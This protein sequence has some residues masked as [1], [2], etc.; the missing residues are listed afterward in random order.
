[1]A[2][3]FLTVRTVSKLIR[4]ESDCFDSLMSATVQ[5][6]LVHLVR[7]W[8]VSGCRAIAAIC[9]ERTG[10]NHFDRPPCDGAFL[11]II[12]QLCSRVFSRIVIVT[13]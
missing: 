5:N 8:S 7:L 9:Q 13:V 1:M 4:I 6:E 11:Y 12:A 10:V 3:G 2:F